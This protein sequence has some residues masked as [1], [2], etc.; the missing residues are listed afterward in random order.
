[1]NASVAS[2]TAT[3]RAMIE[4]RH[5]RAAARAAARRVPV[6]ATLVCAVALFTLADTPAGSGART[7][8]TAFTDPPAL[9]GSEPG[10][11]AA[12]VPGSAPLRVRFDRPMDAASLSAQSITLVG[13]IGAEP[14][15]VIPLGT[16]AIIQP[17]AELLPASRYTLF[18]Q[19]A[20]DTDQRPLPLTAI[21]FDTAIKSAGSPGRLPIATA[22][23][24]IASGPATGGASPPGY[25]AASG[26][27]PL[28][29]GGPVLA[30]SSG[31]APADADA[32][33]PPLG[34]VE[35]VAVA[36]A[37]AIADLGDW[38]PG[39]QHFQGH[40]RADRP[41]SPL[42]SLAPLQASG[43]TALSGQVLGMNGRAVR[44][45]TLRIDGHEVRS[46]RTGRFLLEGLTPGFA[47]LEIDGAT[48]NHGDSFY[49]YYAA[50]VELQPQRTN[51]LPYTI[52]MP[53][54]DPAGTI[55]VAAP[56]TAETIV[57]SPRIPGL[58]LHIPAGTVIRDRQGQIVTDLNLTAIPV[59]RPPF[60]VPDLGVPTYFTIQPGG[61]VLQSVT[62]KP[63][64][65]ARLFYP[66]FKHEVPGARGTFWNYDPEDR[67][68]FVYGLGTISRDSTQ[69]IPDEGVVIHELTGAMFNGG[70]TP[71]AEGPP[72]CG[73][74]EDDECGEGGDPVGL[75]TGQFDHNE[76]D[77]Y[78]DDVIPID[79]TRNYYSYD[80]NQRPFGIGMTDQYD[81][82]LYSQNQWQEVDLILTNGGH[83]H[84]TRISPG[85]DSGTA[86]LQTTTPGIWHNAIVARNLPRAGWDLI[87]R[88]GRR[89][90]FPQFQPLTEITDRNGN[91]LRIVRQTNNGTGGKITQ[92]ISPNGRSV[93][94]SYNAA[95]FV[96]AITDNAGRSYTY[97]YDT[98]G[99]LTTATDPQ[100][101]TR[102]YTW[103]S[104]RL[105]DIHDP[106]G[107]LVVHTS[108]DTLG[109]VANQDFADGAR[110]HYSYTLRECIQPPPNSGQPP[111]ICVFTI[112][113]TD[114]TSLRG[115][116]KRVAF[117]ERGR[118][119]SN[120]YALGLPEQQV[121]RYEYT[122]DLLTAQIDPLN[123]RDEYQYD[124][125]GNLTRLTRLAG[126]SEAA[127]WNT[128]WDATLGRPLTIT[129]PNGN[130]SVMSY[131][132][133]GNLITVQN[134]P[135]EIWTFTYDA[136][137]RRVT[138]TDPLGKTRTLAYD[139]GDLVS[140]TDAL[141]RRVQFLADAVGRR[142]ATVDPL[143]NRW[144]KRWDDLD[145]LISTTDPL[146]GVTS[147]SY[148]ASSNVLDHI[149]ARGHTTSYAYNAINQVTSVQDPL[150]KQATF[151]Y[152]VG[153]RIAQRIDRNG[154]LQAMTYDPVGRVKTVKFGATAAH[155]TAFSSTIDNFWDVAGRLT[156]IV[157]R[158]CTEPTTFLNCGAATVT[159]VISRAYDSF[160][161]MIQEVTPQGEVDYT[162]DAV[163]RRTSMTIK[164]GDTVQPT[165]TYSYD[166]ADRLTTITQ[167]AGDIN[168]G[169][170]QTVTLTHDAAGHR[171]RTTLANGAT[172]DYSY[173]DAGKVTAIVYKTSGGTLIGDL[174]YEY[175]ASGRR[176]SMGGSLARMNLPAADVTDASYDAADRL[177]TWA[178]K[179][180]AYDDHGN[181]ISDGD[182]D[183]Q[184]DDHNRL[185]SIRSGGSTIASFAYDCFGRRTSKTIG[186]TTTG[187]VYDHHNA[188]Q[189]L[190]GATS[191]AGVKAHLLTGRV[192]EVFL[193]LEGNAGA[194]RQS[195]LRDA[196]GHT[197]ALLDAAG[198]SLVNFTYEP[199]GVTTADA[200][201][202][203][204]QQYSGRENDNPGN[205]QGL[206][207]YRARYYM[208]GIGRFIAKDPIGWSSGQT[209]NYAYAGGNP[210]SHIDPS[211]LDSMDA[212]GKG[213]RGGGPRGPR[214]R[215]DPMSEEAG[216]DEAFDQ[217]EGIREAQRRARQAGEGD[218]RIRS[219]EKSKGNVDNRLDRI[220]NAED[221][222]EAARDYR[223]EQIEEQMAEEQAETAAADAEVVEATEAVEVAEAVEV[224]EVVEVA[225]VAAAIELEDV[226]LVLVFCLL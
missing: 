32:Q 10:A 151:V 90:F 26:G 82:F 122:G 153:G 39:P 109:R 141:G 102:T 137:G 28:P 134:A 202:S 7:T 74:N 165:I 164:N 138:S 105:T 114:I 58:E 196:S 144:I 210:I 88:D 47:K 193:R 125:A 188:V 142:T 100:G 139:G 136:Q 187:F 14:L 11:E 60:P 132:A 159:G 191:A 3:E 181:L 68:W 2:M 49:G 48:A 33:L 116:V 72:P 4:G 42:A 84:F 170:V 45:V 145:R 53:R 40:W 71:G 83:V 224:V 177:L 77:L 211:G 119:R 205:A 22:S 113:Q 81:I 133:K 192:D 190:L 89:W 6:A 158:T 64:A 117:D 149:D 124:T 70:N 163:D 24:A 86:V 80:V 118:V 173:D 92:I 9:V 208:P 36:Q 75:A 214:L 223:S 93:D 55:H 101:G 154:Q 44:G 129:D 110:F 29:T 152:E 212:F 176:S 35:Q 204:A 140:M 67:G 226:L 155:P 51:V 126:T 222:E 8:T 63:G 78:L 21:G 5:P 174:Q 160:D 23:A 186:S 179:T 85:T 120:T 104:N 171:T 66:N 157:Q 62:G 94:F 103:T 189:E 16:M 76:H 225:E 178:G 123:R 220:E 25:P 61:A 143:G 111:V 206:Y 185:A 215:H 180:Y 130:S 166:A 54:L 148:D 184:W 216:L 217:E 79:I 52:W 56:T 30:P 200:T 12:G 203:H 20:T 156:L 73:T 201:T 17:T 1:M 27:A 106:N 107:N 209:N 198:A 43:G 183:Y 108:Y 219:I 96:S 50:R 127:S 182:S 161:H 31:A 69:A 91:V 199:Y 128:T 172:V 197:L 46:D 213:G 169:Q 19:G 97:G 175:D 87:F 207:Y 13:P 146:G 221:A 37:D 167:A 135:G 59:D 95:G 147:F 162:Y 65:G 131:D 195:V 18:I 98:D 112:I 121:V 57:R 34:P 150:A 218:E 115:T 194:D 41:P 15:R 99:H 168:G 38:V